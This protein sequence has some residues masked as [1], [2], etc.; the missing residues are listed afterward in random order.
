MSAALREDPCVPGLLSDAN[1]KLPRGLGTRQ[2]L[3]LLQLLG[4]HLKTSLNELSPSGPSWDIARVSPD[5]RADGSTRPVE[6]RKLTGAAAL[7][8]PAGQ[9]FEG[10]ILHHRDTFSPRSRGRGQEPNTLRFRGAICYAAAHT[11]FV[12][13]VNGQCDRSFRSTRPSGETFP[14]HIGIEGRRSSGRR[15]R[16]PW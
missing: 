1:Q 16:S 3:A 6:N 8:N 7:R 5:M 12:R 11:A 9:A 15:L 2:P 4:C 10:E 14:G 13:G